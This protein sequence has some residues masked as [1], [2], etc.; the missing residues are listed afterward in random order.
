ML[1]TG[2]CPIGNL[3]NRR[4][5][6]RSGGSALSLSPRLAYHRWRCQRPHLRSWIGRTSPSPGAASPGSAA[7]PALGHAPGLQGGQRRGF[8]AGGTPQVD[9]PLARVREARLGYLPR[10]T[11]HCLPGRARRCPSRMW[12]DQITAG[13]WSRGRS[14][15]FGRLSHPRLGGVHAVRPE[16]PGAVDVARERRVTPNAVHMARRRVL[17]RVRRVGAI[18]FRPFGR[19]WDSTGLFQRQPRS[20]QYSHSVQDS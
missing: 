19:G 16:G 5:A 17:T 4:E 8:G 1:A 13:W 15:S 9:P 11:V 14:N 3:P 18:L 20:G 10:M 7:V 2:S 6:R 12:R